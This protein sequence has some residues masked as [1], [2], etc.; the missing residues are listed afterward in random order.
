LPCIRIPSDKRPEDK[1]ARTPSP[2]SGPSLSRN[3]A[4]AT[5]KA[6]GDVVVIQDLWSGYD[7]RDGSNWAAREEGTAPWPSPKPWAGATEHERYGIRID[8]EDAE[9][10]L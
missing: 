8:A 2:K 9:R 3:S 5:S 10:R 4:N 6:G 1:S 7:R